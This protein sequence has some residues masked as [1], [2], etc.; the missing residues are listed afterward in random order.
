MMI[1]LPQ[2]LIKLGTINMVLLI[3][4]MAPA[5]LG[6]ST[7]GASTRDVASNEKSAKLKLVGVYYFMPFY[8]HL[9]QNPSRYSRGITTLGCGHPVKVFTSEGRSRGEWDIVKASGRDGFLRQ[10]FLSPKRPPCFEKKYPIFVQKFGLGIDDLFFWG[11]LYDNYVF[12]K[13]KLP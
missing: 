5:P 8:G 1:D 6:A 9:H 12:G 13:V 7:L 11:K 3:S 10:D 2:L 4:L